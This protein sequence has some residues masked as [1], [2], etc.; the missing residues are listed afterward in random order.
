[1]WLAPKSFCYCHD[2]QFHEPIAEGCSNP[3]GYSTQLF[4]K[5][6]ERNFLCSKCRVGRLLW[7]LLMN[8]NYVF[9]T[10]VDCGRLW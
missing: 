10:F 8:L 6:G 1:M 3:A 7:V 5:S 2:L 4:H 9:E